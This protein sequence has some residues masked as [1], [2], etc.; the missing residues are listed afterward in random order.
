MQIE[1][2]TREFIVITLI[3]S[4]WVNASEIFRYFIIV[5]PE[6]HQFLS[7][8]PNVA[9]MNLS[10]FMIWGICD[11]LLSALYV[12]LFWLIANVFGNNTKSILLSGFMAWCFF[13]LLFWVGMANMNLSSWNNLLVVLPLALIETLIAAFITAKLYLKIGT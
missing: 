9:D 11:S 6:M 2:K 10:I 5:R 4:V 7:M 13:F 8:V 1:F 12:F 3:T